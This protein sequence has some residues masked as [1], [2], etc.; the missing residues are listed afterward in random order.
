MEPLISAFELDQ[1]K[2]TVNIGAGNAATAISKMVGKK[3]NMGVPEAIADRIERIPPF[4]GDPSEV[5]TVIL[6]KLMGDV[7][8]MMVL[9]FPPEM[10]AKI[11]ALLTGNHKKQVP[12]LDELD[13]SALR[14]MGNVVAGT[15]LSALGRFLDL[16]IIQSM[17]DTATDMLGATLDAILLDM[18][19]VTETMLAFKVKI[20]I[21]EEKMEGKL[22]F[23]FDPKATTTILAAAKKKFP[24]V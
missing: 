23:M 2:E 11:A 8:G 7:T 15:S 18:G 1:L 24:N 3:I 22:F 6:L 10:A 21:E 20:A 14:E 17:P 12:I 13:R 9:L 5:M 19:Q 16:N 4:V